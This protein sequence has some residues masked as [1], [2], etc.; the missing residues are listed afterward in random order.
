MSLVSRVKGKKMGAEDSKVWTEKVGC[1]LGV[2]ESF[3]ASCTADR[4]VSCHRADVYSNSD[5]D[6]MMM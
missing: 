6:D 5:Y 4:S 1:V 3:A 2:W